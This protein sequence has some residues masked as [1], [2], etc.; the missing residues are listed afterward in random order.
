M[1]PSNNMRFLVPQFI[2]IEDKLFGPLSF[3][4]FV[5]VVGS[6]AFAGAIYATY[7]IFLAILFGGPV[8]AAGF[9]LAF[10]RV[11]DRPFIYVLQAGVNYFIK[12][13][14]Y[15]W[16]KEA[17]QARSVSVTQDQTLKVYAPKISESKLKELAWSLDIKESVYTQEPE[18]QH[19]VSSIPGSRH[20]H[21]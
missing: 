18:P 7:G 2:E 4:Q 6:L 10:Y 3:K 1:N 19:H 17:K 8:V 21:S 11:N 12:H 13:K 5:Y 20:T 16:K 15:L 9:A 14:L